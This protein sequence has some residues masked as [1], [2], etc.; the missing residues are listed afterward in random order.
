MALSDLLR[1]RLL[2]R[3][4]RPACLIWNASK[5]RP[6]SLLCSTL[7]P[8]R[9]AKVPSSV[10]QALLQSSEGMHQMQEL[11]TTVTALRES[12]AAGECERV[13]HHA[14]LRGIQGILAV[15]SHRLAAPPMFSSTV[16]ASGP[17]LED[18]TAAPSVKRT[19]HS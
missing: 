5:R 8:P 14:K 10:E 13:E 2:P 18:S 11:E 15:V 9:G 19:H 7:A 4:N 17:A 3:R 16:G 12:S 1:C 6:R